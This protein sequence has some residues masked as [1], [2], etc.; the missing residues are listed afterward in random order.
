VTLEAHAESVL[1]LCRRMLRDHALAEDV[2]Q[3]VLL[4][5]HR[6]FDRFE[7]RSSVR[8]WLLAIANH[9]CHDAIKARQRRERRICLDDTAVA[10]VADPSG[11]PAAEVAR[12]Q[13]ARALDGCLARL[14]PES[15]TALVLRFYAG[16]S[17]EEMSAQLQVKSDT[18]QTRVMR[19]LPVIR[20]CL[21]TKG[22]AT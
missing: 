2:Q 10:D 6:D 4:E 5:A 22:W 19:A 18:L 12:R 9:R 14:S 1:A 20:R 17:Y 16:M 11:G 8:H 21:E 7:G 3:Q 13:L 15:R